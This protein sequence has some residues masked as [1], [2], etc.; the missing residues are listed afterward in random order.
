M[1]INVIKKNH[2]TLKEIEKERQ[3]LL[4]TAELLEQQEMD[5]MSFDLPIDPSTEQCISKLKR[6]ENEIAQFKTK[7]ES[8]IFTKIGTHAYI[9]F[10]D[11]DVTK[12]LNITTKE[13]IIAKFV[14]VDY[15]NK[16]AVHT[17]LYHQGEGATLIGKFSHDIRG[18]NN[19]NN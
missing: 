2:F 5:D 8:A 4:L 3:K 13:V 9:L 19:A 12:L 16:T 6:T 11:S 7:V 18:E 10:T 17:E 1:E 14:I 15:G